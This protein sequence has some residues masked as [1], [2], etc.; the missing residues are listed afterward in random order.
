MAVYW[1]EAVVFCHLALLTMVRV[2]RSS[3]DS[4]LNLSVAYSFS[5]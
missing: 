3:L 1:D 5:V 4:L 2:D